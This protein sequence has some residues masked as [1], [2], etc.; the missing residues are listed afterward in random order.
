MTAIETDLTRIA[1]LA[2]ARQDQFEVLR[3]QLQR[4]DELED[5]QIDAFVEQIAAPIIAAIDC[6][7]C[8]NCCHVLDVYLT[9]Q[10]ADTLAAGIHIPLD[11]LLT[12]YIDREAAEA[13]DEWGKFRARPCAFLK[14]KLCSVYEH[15][16]ES[17]RMYPVFT[18]D[19][20]WTLEDTIAGAGVCPI[21]YNV[22][23]TMVEQVDRLYA[24]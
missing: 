15:R 18:P 2:K 9:P 13:V 22:L 20:R 4:D 12:D 23:S 16:P 3:Y 14:G 19:F 17:C 21:I 10:D 5:S 6:K 24:R 7:Q 8:A 11:T 1:A